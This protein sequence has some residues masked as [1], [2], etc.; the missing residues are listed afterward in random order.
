MNFARYVFI[1]K[2]FVVVVVVN[3]C[4][5]SYFLLS[6]SHSTFRLHIKSFNVSR[7]V[8]L[9]RIW[10]KQEWQA[11]VSRCKCLVYYGLP[12]PIRWSIATNCG[13]CR[14]EVIVCVCWR[15]STN[16]SNFDVSLLNG[17]YFLTFIHSLFAAH[18]D[19]KPNWDRRKQWKIKIWCGQII[20]IIIDTSIFQDSLVFSSLSHCQTLCRA[21]TFFGW[22]WNNLY[23]TL[24]KKN[25]KRETGGGGEVE[26]CDRKGKLEYR[27]HFLLTSMVWSNKK[28]I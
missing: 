10:C 17:I 7:T 13:T 6:S 2:R 24:K 15:M 23:F 26:R 28:Q 9:L 12:K 22:C 5:E 8:S 19:R 4:F 21:H 11:V 3:S 1:S 14:F 16:K 25:Q 18:C 27:A 20:P